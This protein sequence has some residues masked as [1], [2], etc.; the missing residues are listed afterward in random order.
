LSWHTTGTLSALF[1]CDFTLRLRLALPGFSRFLG[2]PLYRD[3]QKQKNR[4]VV[5]NDIDDINAERGGWG[6]SA[7]SSPPFE[8]LQW[9][10][11]R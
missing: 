4:I 1:I 7:S 6:F 10:R 3:P 5:S 8:E 2:P 9:Q 11:G